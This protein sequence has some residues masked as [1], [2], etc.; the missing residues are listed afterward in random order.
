MGFNVAQR[1]QRHRALRRGNARREDERAGVV[2]GEVHHLRACGHVAAQA[3]QGLGE[4]AHVDVHFILQTV[5]T[6]RAASAVAQHAKAVGVVHHDPRAILL[7]Q[8]ADLRQVRDVALHAEHAVGHDQA[9][10][11]VRNLLELNFQ[12]LHVLVAVGQHAAVAQAAAVVDGGVVLAIADHVVA[13]AHDGRN[14]AQVALEAGGEGHHGLLVQEARQLG[15]QLQMHLQRAVQEAGARAARA[16][17][18]QRVQTRLD[19]LRV[20][21][22]SQI[23]V[24]AQHDAALALHLHLGG[25]TGLQ[26][27]EVGVDALRTEFVGEGVLFTFSKYVRVSLFFHPCKLLSNLRALPRDLLNYSYYTLLIR[28]SSSGWRISNHLGIKIP[29]YRLKRRVRRTV[30]Q[31]IGWP[32]SRCKGFRSLFGTL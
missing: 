31:A 7:R 10:R 17:L 8:A 22:K 11:S 12:L 28:F 6:G 21:R 32:L 2:A 20:L 3:G 23:V 1:G 5:I 19:D 14:D 26:R 24:R 27:V 30:P 4:G 18:L 13:V 9:A 16:V 25:L 15:L 29:P